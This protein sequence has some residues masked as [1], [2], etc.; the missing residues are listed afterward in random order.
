MSCSVCSGYSS[1]NCPCCGDEPRM[2]LCPH[3]KGTGEQDWMVFD[4]KDRIAVEC[5]ESAYLYA[6]EDEDTAEYL[7]KRYCK[8]SCTCKT[9]NGEGEI[10]EN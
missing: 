7:G 2:T 5:I 10:P 1:R 6:P 4:I 3:C 9:C 8:L